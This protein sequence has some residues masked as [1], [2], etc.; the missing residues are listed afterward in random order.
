MPVS[1]GV[2]LSFL[3][4]QYRFSFDK[5]R[6][7]TIEMKCLRCGSCCVMLDVIIVDDPE[8]GIKEDNLKHKPSGERCQHLLGNVFGEMSCSI[9]DRPWYDETPCASHGQVESKVTNDC[10][11]GAY[12]LALK[13]SNEYRIWLLSKLNKSSPASLLP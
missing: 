2:R 8:L 6:K 11:T 3:P 10:R 9:H 5:G 4:C 7:G 12:V 13:S 1:P